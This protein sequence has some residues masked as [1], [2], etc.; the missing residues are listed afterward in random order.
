MDEIDEVPGVL[1]TFIL[2]FAPKSGAAVGK[3]NG[4][5][6]TFGLDDEE[7]YICKQ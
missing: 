4:I 1:P 2:N 3:N 6:N 5:G 7:S